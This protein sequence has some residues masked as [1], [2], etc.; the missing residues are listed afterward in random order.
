MDHIIDDFYVA[1]VNEED[2]DEL[3]EEAEEIRNDQVLSVMLADTVPQINA[4]LVHPFTING[5]NLTGTGQGVCVV[6]TGVNGTHEDLNGRVIAEHC[7]CDVTDYGSGGCCSDNTNEN[8]VG[9]D[10]HSH[11]THVAGIVGANGTNM[12][13]VAPNVNIIAVKVTNASGSAYLSDITEGIDWCVTNADTYNISVITISL[14]GGG[15]YGYC[16]GSYG[17]AAAAINDAV[18]QNITVTIATG[19]YW[20]SY[21]HQIG[22]PACIENATAVGAVDKSDVVYSSYQRNDITDLMAPGRN[23]VSLSHA[24]GITLKSGT[25]MAT[26]HVAGVVAIL[27]QYFEMSSQSPNV[28]DIQSVLNNTGFPVYDAAND[29]T[30]GRVSLLGALN[31]FDRIEKIHPSIIINKCS[32]GWFGI[33]S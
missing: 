18:A 20:S 11:G 16:D 17:A 14:G 15:F 28:S 6:D 19:N 22:T 21:P 29:T 33:S 27:N 7:F 13:G 2:L 26:P 9:K 31:E 30:W 24:G 25:S 32:R 23:V 12:L 5:V 1:A 8:S 3:I 4:T 10:D